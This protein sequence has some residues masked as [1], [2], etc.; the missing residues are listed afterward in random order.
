MKLSITTLALL[1]VTVTPAVHSK[2]TTSDAAGNSSVLHA[3]LS[4]KENASP[5]DQMYRKLFHEKLYHMYAHE[6]GPLENVLSAKCFNAYL[7]IGL[8]RY[9]NYLLGSLVGGQQEFAGGLPELPINQAKQ[10]YDEEDSLRK[11]N[12]G[13]PENMIIEGH[14]GLSAAAGVCSTYGGSPRYLYGYAKGTSLSNYGSTCEDNIWNYDQRIICA[15]NDGCTDQELVDT[16]VL[17]DSYILPFYLSG[18][19]GGLLDVQ[20]RDLR[21]L[22]AD[23]E[24]GV[25]LAEKMER[26]LQYCKQSDIEVVPKSTKSNKAGK[27]KSDK[28]T[29]KRATRNLKRQ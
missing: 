17:I 29:R 5:P 25:I 2:D 16:T 1:L 26:M 28:K 22:S 18:M 11:L 6:D 13:M 19:G 14:Q 15:P 7:D 27:S 3:A 24:E 21:N 20:R 23:E 10:G 4:K 8:A 9:E 12:V